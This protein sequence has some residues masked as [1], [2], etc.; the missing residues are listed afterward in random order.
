ML[1]PT[2]YANAS[3]MM[4]TSYWQAATDP[5]TG[6]TRTSNLSRYSVTWVKSPTLRS[7]KVWLGASDYFKLWVNGAL[8]LSRTAGGSK[9]CAV[10]EYKANVT[11][12]AGWNL[13]VLKQSFPQLGPATD[14]RRGSTSTS[15]SRFGSCRTI[16][17]P[18]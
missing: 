12:V 11:L 6:A 17:A 13:I 7:A 10:D 4:M 14:P 2:Y 1:Y 15:S 16:L 9:P 5:A 8:L 3:G 18:R